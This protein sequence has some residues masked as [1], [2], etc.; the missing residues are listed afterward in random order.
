MSYGTDVPEPL[1]RRRK[2]GFI[3]SAYSFSPDKKE[4]KKKRK[5]DKTVVMSG[6]FC[7]LAM[8]LL[9]MPSLLGN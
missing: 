2:L 7:T 6:Q 8:F 1:E 4:A 9:L 5:K 3:Q